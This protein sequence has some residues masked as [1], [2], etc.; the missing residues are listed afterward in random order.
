M[1]PR[2]HPAEIPDQ[3]V[4]QDAHP[5]DRSNHVREGGPFDAWPYAHGFCRPVLGL[6]IQIGVVP[7]PD[8]R[9]GQ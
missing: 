7:C 6:M 2:V 5:L 4:P 8:A 3:R 1:P 9:S